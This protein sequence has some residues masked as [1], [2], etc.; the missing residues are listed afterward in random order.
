MTEENEKPKEAKPASIQKDLSKDVGL[1]VAAFEL[2]KTATSYTEGNSEVPGNIV[3]GSGGVPNPT[4]FRFIGIA[5][6]QVIKESQQLIIDKAR[7]LIGIELDK[8]K[9]LLK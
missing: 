5:E 3:C 8:I 6:K 4:L 2:S 9:E 7:G 1:M